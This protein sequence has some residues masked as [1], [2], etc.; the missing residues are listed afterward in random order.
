M[1]IGLTAY[2]PPDIIIK[3]PQFL[4]PVAEGAKGPG[5][6]EVSYDET[7]AEMRNATLDGVKAARQWYYQVRITC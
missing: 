7:L 2:T 4:P 5:C 3:L 6:M 1:F